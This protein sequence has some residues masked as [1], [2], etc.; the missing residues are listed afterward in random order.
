MAQVRIDLS[1]SLPKFEA[2][3]LGGITNSRGGFY[4]VAAMRTLPRAILILVSQSFNPCGRRCSVRP[5][6]VRRPILALG[7]GAATRV[8]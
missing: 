6:T 4:G 1:G 5:Q 8:G 2:D 7:D 3:A